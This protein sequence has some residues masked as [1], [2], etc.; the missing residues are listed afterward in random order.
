MLLRSNNNSICQKFAVFFHGNAEDV[1]LA[2]EIL[3]HIRF[4]LGV[5]MNINKK[6]I[7]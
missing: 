1:N 3:N 6:K 7:I 5:N 4:T 2:Y